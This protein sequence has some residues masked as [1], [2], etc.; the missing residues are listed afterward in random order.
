MR[1][2]LS[3]IALAGCAAGTAMAAD[4]VM[5]VFD[6]SN[7]MWGQIDG[8][9][10]I[11][12]ARRSME[13]LMGDWVEGTN[14][15]LIA[16]GH[17][18][19]GDCTDIET[20]IPPGPADRAAFIE[21]IGAITPRGKTPLTAAVE[22]AARQL[23]YRD[24]P[25]TVVLISDGIE[26]CQRDPC[27]LAEELERSGVDFTAHV[28]GFGL[29]GE[30]EQAAIACIAD[31]TGGRF[32]AAGNAG[33]L[34]DALGAVSAEVAAADEAEPEP[35]LAPVARMP[36]PVTAPESVTA[37]AN[38]DVG[39]A[40]ILDEADIVTIVP[41]QA[42]ESEVGNH[43]RVRGDVSGALRAPADTGLYEVR[44]VRHQG[45]TVAGRQTVEV[46][47]AE[48]QV[49][50]PETAIAGSS[51]DVS[52]TGAIHPADFVTVVPAGADEGTVEDH[53]RVR[54]NE[55]DSLRAPADP[56]LYEVR[57]VLEEGRRTLASTPIEVTEPQVQ[58]TATDTVRAGDEIEISWS[59]DVPHP[60]DYITIVP[61]GAAEGEV[62]D[63][64]RVGSETSTTLRAPAETGVY[65]VRYVLGNGRRTLASATV[66]VV[67]ATATLDT[68]GSLTAPETAAPGEEV[69]VS[70]TSSS[71][72]DRQRV[73]LA[74]RDQADFVWI[75]AKPAANAPPL[76][77]VMPDAPGLYEFRL[78]D[79]TGPQ[80]LS[81]A[82]IEVR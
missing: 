13:S 53:V 21:R 68:G 39:W 34:G 42:E 8:T 79:L 28:I 33:E 62:Q 61:L 72:S 23:L 44:Y 54:D 16:Y 43:L 15:G 74:R 18:R 11:E 76:A 4:D 2:F 36:V 24:N 25:A 50:A 58:V 29:A 20:I 48:A 81:R 27:A 32:I 73:A 66:E 1:Q 64:D 69:Q 10:K 55:S 38:F 46:T 82:T 80:V 70:W 78:L 22:E 12:I 31:R 57:Y 19:E 7:S 51:F 40:E 45:R 17:R 47:P 56:G 37:G 6:G 52:W 77:F 67:G 41:I 49:T 5:V 3:T 65:E 35:E 75:D 14:L 9:A 71:A 26:S 59:G 60:G 63:H 30:E